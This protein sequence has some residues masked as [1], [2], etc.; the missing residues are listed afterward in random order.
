ME[1]TMWPHLEF[2]GR[3]LAA[4]FFLMAAIYPAYALGRRLLPRCSLILRCCGS[5]VFFMVLLSVLFHVLLIWRHFTVPAALITAS[6]VTLAVRLAGNPFMDT[7]IAFRTD[8]HFIFRALGRSLNGPFRYFYYLCLLFIG[9]TVLR[10]LQIPPIAWDSLIYH[11]VKPALWVQSGG[12]IPMMAPAG[13]QIQ[14]TYHGGGE[15]FM[16][17]A[18]LF[19]HSDL[20]AGLVDAAE[21]TGL[22]LV[23]Y[24]IGR[25]LRIHVRARWTGLFYVLFVPAL[26]RSVGSGYVVICLLLTGMLG[27]LFMLV[28]FRKGT[29]TSLILSGLAFGLCAGVKITM[30]SAIIMVWGLVLIYAFRNRHGRMKRLLHFAAATGCILFM[31][32]PW[33]IRSVYHSGYPLG[34]MPVSLF[35]IDLGA[36]T[37]GLTYILERPEMNAYRP[38]AEIRAFFELFNSPFAPHTHMSILTLLP[39][40]LCMA[41]VIKNIRKTPWPALAVF[42]WTSAVLAVYYHPSFSSLRLGWALDNGRFML[43]ML[44]PVVLYGFTSFHRKSRLAGPLEWAFMAFTVLHIAAFAF[45]GWIPLEMLAVFILAA[46]IAVSLMCIGWMRRK[47]YRTLLVCMLLL[48]PVVF[49]SMLKFYRDHSR[50]VLASHSTLNHD[51]KRYW[52]P[53]SLHSDVPGTETR[54]AVT[55]GPH[56]NLMSWFTYFFLGRDFQ[57]RID[58]LPVTRDGEIVDFHPD[59]YHEVNGC[60]ECWLNRLAEERIDY[61]MSFVPTSLELNWMRSHPEQFEELYSG[62]E[63]EHAEWGFFKVIHIDQ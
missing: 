17:W 51:F 1:T 60:F 38:G 63:S 47:S 33:M 10:T 18:M 46:G 41:A 56:R 4:G 58:F 27:F 29:F 50:Y 34:V 9:L 25:E 54:I 28:Y 14:L 42:G 26:C 40:I 48:L 11:A 21:W 44:G 24:E 39:M 16:A 55:S 62:S 7:F 19:F 30:M 20:L 5:I 23:L 32:I 61:V 2:A 43:P 31:I 15:V 36:P 3:T 53:A 37:S 35:G 13:W 8:I 6:A 12:P 49:L 52:I 57:N 22:A 45:R 59:N